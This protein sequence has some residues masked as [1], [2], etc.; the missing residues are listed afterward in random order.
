[1]LAV[2]VLAS[3]SIHT[4]APLAGP[5]LAAAKKSTGGTTTLIFFVLLFGVG[6]MFLI[7]PQRQR[8]QRQLQAGKQISVGDKVMLSSGIIGRVEGFVG[9]HA[10]IE[11]APGTV[12][13]VIRAAVSQ[14][15]DEAAGDDHDHSGNSSFDERHHEDLVDDAG[16]DPYSVAPLETGET[17]D[18]GDDADGRHPGGNSSGGSGR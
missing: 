15:V 5:L 7:R 4:V 12:I 1:M 18:P 14:R 3:S 10:R 13:E 16:H 6:Y 9:D 11:I 17:T 2:H 8:R